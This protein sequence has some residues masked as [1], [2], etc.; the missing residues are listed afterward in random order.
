MPNGEVKKESVE[1]KRI[2]ILALAVLLLIGAA[3]V[4]V[5]PLVSN[6][7]ND[8]YQSVV[9]TE[10]VQELERIDSETMEAALEAA[11]EYN[12]NLS[13]L[14]YNK[15]AVAAASLDYDRVL[16]LNGSGI[17][18]YVEIPKLD[19]YLPIYHG[20]GED[21]LEKGVGHLTGSSL[22]IGGDSCHTILTG[23][24]GVAGKRLFSDLDQ[25]QEGDVFFL[26]VLDETLAYQVSS[27]SK[28]LPYETALLAP[29][30]GKDL[31][32]LVT[33]Y[34]YGVNT[35]RLLVRGERIPYKEATVIA[36]EETKEPVRSTWK[37]QYFCG[38][39]IGGGC[40]AGAA[41]FGLLLSW[42]RKKRR[43]SHEK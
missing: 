34:P 41:L 19:I 5:Y 29:V 40:A 6:Y 16:N 28:V 11:M 1:L 12:E 33:C 23:H 37:E 4:T 7:I 8:K 35:H 43:R 15:E 3:G 42:L 10:Y 26:H 18:G 39:A 9:C 25:M 17:M 13:P 38:L 32:S 31:C 24:S 21:A 27:V 36:K 30:R 2:A 20:T 14:R 22:P